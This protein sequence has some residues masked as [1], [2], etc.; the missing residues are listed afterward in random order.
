MAEADASLD[1]A[2]P[3]SA[4]APKV[5]NFGL[6]RDHLPM[7]DDVARRVLEDELGQPP[8]GFS[9]YCKKFQDKL[10]QDIFV[11]DKGWL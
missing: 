4:Q 9:S 8:S 5:A 7:S 10:R 6:G 3:A 2:P 11:A 1:A